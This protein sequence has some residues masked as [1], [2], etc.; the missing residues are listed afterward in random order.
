MIQLRFAFRLHRHLKSWQ[1]AVVIR[2]SC[3]INAVSNNGHNYNPPEFNELTQPLCDVKELSL[4]ENLA[5]YGVSVKQALQ[6][7]PKLE[8]RVAIAVRIE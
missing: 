2:R 5:K 3:N 7:D 4:T 1:S 6:L 8:Q